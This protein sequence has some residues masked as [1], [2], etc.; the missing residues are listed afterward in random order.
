MMLLLP[1]SIRDTSGISRPEGPACV[2]T[3]CFYPP[4]NQATSCLT[5][6]PSILTAAAAA[7]AARFALFMTRFQTRLFAYCNDSL[8]VGSVLVSR[9]ETSTVLVV[10]A[11]RLRSCTYCSCTSITCIP[12]PLPTP[13]T[14]PT[15]RLNTGPQSSYLVQSGAAVVSAIQVLDRHF[16]Y[17]AG[18]FTSLITAARFFVSLVSSK[19]TTFALYYALYTSTSV[20]SGEVYHFL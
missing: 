20:S 8:R 15:H 16:L 10:L 2:C 11:Q 7:A 9:V 4:I 19:S 3:I 17:F 1:F 5:L 14:P 12:S 6:E 13:S 18:C